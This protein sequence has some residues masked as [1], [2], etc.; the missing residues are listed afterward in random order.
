MENH[1]IAI[2]GLGRVGTV[3][4]ERMLR[5]KG[6]GTQIVC[7]V[8]PQHTPGKDLAKEAGIRVVELDEMIAMSDEIEV[9][10]DLSGDSYIKKTLREKLAAQGNDYT[11]IAP[12]NVARLVWNVMDNQWPLPDFHQQKGY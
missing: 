8:E 11:V 9:I 5:L 4:I 3:F 6:K 12:E 2:V 7:A 1:H 10:F